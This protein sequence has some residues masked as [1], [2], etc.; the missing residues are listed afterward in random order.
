M[1]CL[2]ISSNICFGFELGIGT[3]FSSYPGNPQTYLSLIKSYGFTSIRDDYSWNKIEMVKGEF[4]ANGKIEKVDNAIRLAPKYNLNMLVILDYGNKS[5]NSNY[6]PN[7]ADSLNAY[8]KYVQW[9][10]KHLKG[11]VKYYEIWN[12]WNIGT[13]VNHKGKLPPT[14]DDYLR[15]VKQVSAVIRKEDPQALILAG[16]INP[17]T[18][19]KR[20]TNI[21]DEEWMYQ[22]ID[23]GIL[24]YIDGIS[25]HPYSYANDSKVLRSPTGN[26]DGID[27]FHNSI[28]HKYGEN[29]SFYITEMGIPTYNGLGGVTVNEQSSFIESYTKGVMKRSYIKGIWWYDLIDDGSNQLNK[30]DNFG[31]LFNNLNPKP[32]ML[33]LK[34]SLKNN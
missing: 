29:V 9:T 32:T 28:L 31:L 25:L 7:T 26:L 12:E 3:H 11:K 8:V 33:N 13:G 19:K 15:L 14:V 30:E 6:Y 10:V 18:M 17:L 24:K 22:L 4:D 34:K 5:Y 27:K 2:L 1:F 23:K 20:F 16:S 21:S